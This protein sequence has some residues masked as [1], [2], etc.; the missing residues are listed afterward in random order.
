MMRENLLGGP[1]E[2]L[3]PDNPEA[4][5]ALA[6]ERRLARHNYVSLRPAELV[7]SRPANS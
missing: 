5:A 2:T 1:P 6:A 4:S 3:L 7:R